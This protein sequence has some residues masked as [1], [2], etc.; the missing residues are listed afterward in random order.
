[1]QGKPRD[2]WFRGS[3]AIVSTASELSLM[4]EAGYVAY[5]ATKG[6]ILAM[7][8]AL[9]AELAPFAIRVNAVCPGATDTPMLR[10]EYA[11]SPDPDVGRS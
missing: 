3:G 5:T 1:M 11:T 7:T 2:A 6:A 10:A 8:R 4:G 9:A